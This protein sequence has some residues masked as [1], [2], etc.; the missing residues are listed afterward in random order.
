MPES[1]AGSVTPSIAFRHLPPKEGCRRPVLGLYDGSYD[2]PKNIGGSLF[3]SC[4]EGHNFIEVVLV[5]LVL[6]PR[7]DVSV[8]CFG[9]RPKD[10]RKCV[11]SWC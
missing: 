2:G 7:I 4:T 1:D 8:S 10:R 3:Y 6:D 11:S 5:V 9:P